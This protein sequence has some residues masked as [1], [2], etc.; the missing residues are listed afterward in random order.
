MFTFWDHFVDGTNAQF[1]EIVSEIV[2]CESGFSRDIYYINYARF[3]P[4]LNYLIN[5]QTRRNEYGGKI[6]FYLLTCSLH[7]FTKKNVDSEFVDSEFVKTCHEQVVFHEYWKY[8]VK[9]FSFITWKIETTVEFFSKKA[10]R[11]CSFIKDFRVR[12]LKKYSLK[13]LVHKLF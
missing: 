12:K 8:G 6:F 2:F 7:V 3:H 1:A 11:S 10:K 13:M 4:T 9:N 5:E